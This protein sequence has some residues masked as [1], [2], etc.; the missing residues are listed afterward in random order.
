VAEAANPE[1]ISVPLV[2]WNIYSALAKV[3][4]IHLV[5]Q[6]RNREA[7]KRTGLIEGIDFSVIDNERF[8]AP[9]GNLSTFI[10]GDTGKGWT[11]GA[12]FS[13]FAYY[14]FE[15]GL[16][17]KFKS[18]LLARE[19]DLVHRVTP[20]SPT[21]QSI[22]AKRL[23]KIGIPFV[24]GPLNGGVPWPKSF[25]DRQHAEREW[26]SH[27]RGIYKLMPGYRSMRRHSSAIIVG[28]KSTLSEMPRSVQN[29]CVYVPENG[30][31][32]DQAR[33][34]P[35][36]RGPKLRAIFIGRL[37][38]Y[39]GADM[40]LEAAFDY[41]RDGQLEIRIVGDGPQRKELETLVQ[42]LGIQDA[43]H[44]C[45]LLSHAEALIQ[46]Q[47]S[48]FLIL[49]SIREF[50]GGVVVESMAMGVTPI[51][52]NYAGPAELVDDSTGIRVSFCD[53]RTLI[54]GLKKAIKGIILEP[55]QLDRFGQAG[56][57]KVLEKFT[58][59][60]KANQLLRVYASVLAGA[61]DLSK[62]EFY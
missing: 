54:E 10:R 13:S 43:V 36:R 38:P 58:W 30:I 45:G 20:L 44:F 27:V 50:G 41:I 7:I 26:L 11:I 5:T 55:D 42:E 60:A 19:F 37:V 3:V 6:I 46:L 61:T 9:F 12:A 14:S 28:S 24:V 53:R 31:R 59:E 25:I 22:I 17:H 29:K 39:K 32:A 18:R 33:F 56:L 23:W 8:A 40:M 34:E 62:L 49:P 47:A 21:S 48:D 4:D 15:L 35:K 16:W 57:K 52:A 51:V 1:W 2:G